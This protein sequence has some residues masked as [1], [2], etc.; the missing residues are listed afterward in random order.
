MREEF[1]ALL[2][3]VAELATLVRKPKPLLQFLI[4]THHHTFKAQHMTTTV[5]RTHAPID[6]AVVFKAVDGVTEK[7]AAVPAWSVSD[8]SLM[9]VVAGEDGMSAVA[10]LTGAEGHVVVSVTADGVTATSEFT[11]EGLP[12][13]TAE[14]VVAPDAPAADA[15]AAAPAA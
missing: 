9:T 3:D 5:L 13:T 14:I 1:L 12:V 6:L 11:I 4:Y 7:P 10:T 15:P 8:V 2:A